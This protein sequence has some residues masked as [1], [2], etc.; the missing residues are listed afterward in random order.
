MWR[1]ILGRLIQTS[2]S[3]FW[4]HFGNQTIWFSKIWFTKSESDYASQALFLYAAREDSVKIC[5]W[6]LFHGTESFYC[7]TFWTKIKYD[8]FGCDNIVRTSYSSSTKR[9][10]GTKQYDAHSWIKIGSL[11]KKERKTAIILTNYYYYYYY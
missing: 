7:I 11:W 9:I 8:F 1:I 6:A 2:S 10:I 5:F 3:C 4:T